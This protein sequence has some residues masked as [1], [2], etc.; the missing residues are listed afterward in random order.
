MSKTEKQL[1]SRFGSLLMISLM[2]SFAGSLSWAYS[3]SGISS[4]GFMAAQMATI[5]SSQF[6]HIGVVAGGY[7]GCA[8]NHYQEQM[9]LSRKNLQGLTVFFSAEFDPLSIWKGDLKHALQ[10]APLNPLYQ[11]LSICMQK[12]NLALPMQEQLEELEG[13]KLIDRRENLK[14][15]K[16]LIYHG[17]KDSVV[18]PEMQN[19]HKDF[20][21]TAGVLPENI[22]ILSSNGGHNFPTDKKSNG[23]CSA[24]SVP[25]LAHCKLDLAGEILRKALNKSELLRSAHPIAKLYKVSQ[26]VDGVKPNSIAEYG[27]LAA[28][29]SCLENPT[30]CHLHV[31]LHGCEMSDSFDENFDKLYAQSA[32]RRYLQMR[33]KETAAMA[34]WLRLPYIEQ[35]KPKMGALKFAQGAGYLDYVSDENRLMVLFPQT[36]IGIENY[37]GNP[38][39]CW[40]WYGY[41]GADYLTNQ[42]AEPAW[43]MKFIQ[44]VARDPQFGIL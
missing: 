4:G 35:R 11:A 44:Q 16:Y 5:Y 7:F 32:Q 26:F 9:E 27:Y 21:T 20:L 2:M 28:S 41:T 39:G 34:P 6:S 36:W 14:N 18:L 43:L 40:D 23:P 3:I 17:K 15:Q 19:I 12:P 37:P 10:L 38:K 42:G 13:K 24:Q 30:S 8:R 22:Q 25:Y 1:V 31:A 33:D 29:Q